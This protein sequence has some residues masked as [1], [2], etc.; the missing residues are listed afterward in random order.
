[1]S[2]EATGWVLDHSTTE[3]RDR[4][5]LLV[6][7]W[8]A[9]RD[10]GECWPGQRLI[11][12]EARCSIGTVSNAVRRLAQLGE[13]EVERGRGNRPS[14]YRML[15]LAVPA[16]AQPRAERN[17][18]QP[19]AERN[20]EVCVQSGPAC[21]QSEAVSAQPRA[22]RN[23]NRHIEPSRARA[24]EADPPPRADGGG[25]PRGG[26]GPA[27]PTR[28]ADEIYAEHVAVERASPEIAAAALAEARAAIGRP[29]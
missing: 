22:E 1:M 26:Q 24:R 11:A 15:W 20:G 3:G 13:I 23:P 25:G 16:S 21:V 4:L 2:I 10:S 19:R 28:T 5:V 12:R 9:E 7:A 17:G 27:L 8:H 29:G 14:R 18:A 6:I